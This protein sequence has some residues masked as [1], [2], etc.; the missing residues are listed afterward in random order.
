M[1]AAVVVVLAD[2]ESLSLAVPRT[3]VDHGAMQAIVL[4]L[5]LLEKFSLPW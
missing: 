3:V 5:L 1:P 2:Y 4:L